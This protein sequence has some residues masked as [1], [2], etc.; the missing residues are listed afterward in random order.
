[1]ITPSSIEYIS[2]VLNEPHAI[3]EEDHESIEALVSAYPYFVPARYMQAAER[4]KNKPFEPFMM[5]TMKLYDGNWLL[6]HEYLKK[7]LGDRVVETVYAMPQPEEKTIRLGSVEEVAEGNETTTTH[8]EDIYTIDNEFETIIEE[9]APP[10][11]EDVRNK[12]FTFDQVPFKEEPRPADNEETL[13]LPVYT[14]DYFLHQGVSVSNN[15]PAEVDKFGQDDEAAKSLMVVMSFSEWLNHFKIRS[16]KAREEEHDQRALKTMWQKEKL[17]AAL[18]EENEEIP[19]NVFEMAVNSI[20]REDD[21]ASES[22]ADIY[23]KQGKYDAAMDMYKKLSLRFPQKSAY[24]AR[25]IDGI[26]K[27]KTT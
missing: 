2:Q 3:T 25:K 5:A 11:Q 22:L 26:L 8:Y 23:A 16:E 12:E 18:E 20:A 14:E 1:M 10:V 21:L 19:E 24:F 7:S 17:V 4:H 15:I 13:I 6:L 27:E 9:A